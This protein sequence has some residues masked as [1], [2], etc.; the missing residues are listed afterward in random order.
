MPKSTED[1]LKLAFE[2]EL[3]KE[4][5]PLLYEI[6]ERINRLDTQEQRDEPPKR[7]Q[8]GKSAW[9]YSMIK[10]KCTIGDLKDDLV[11]QRKLLGTL[12]HRLPKSVIEQKEEADQLK[13]KLEEKEK[14]KEKE[15]KKAVAPTSTSTSTPQPTEV[16]QSKGK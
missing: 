6:N 15:R 5:K 9:D 12:F 8:F 10:Y 7:D 2:T 13:L 3:R 14:E 4:I 1:L 11:A 16:K